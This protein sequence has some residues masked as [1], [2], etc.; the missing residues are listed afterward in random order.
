MAVWR[1][2]GVL[3][4]VW[5]LGCLWRLASLAG[6]GWATWALL[7]TGAAGNRVHSASTP[8][9]LCLVVVGLVW[10]LA[11]DLVWCLVVGHSTASP[12]NTT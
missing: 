2:V 11:V 5:C 7:T 8:A 9:G 10:L 12:S 4:A 3:V 6:V 1:L